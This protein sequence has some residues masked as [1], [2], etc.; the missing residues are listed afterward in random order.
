[1]GMSDK[2][3]CESQKRPELKGKMYCQRGLF[4]QWDLNHE[5]VCQGCEAVMQYIE[6]QNPLQETIEDK[7]RYDIQMGS[8]S[9]PEYDE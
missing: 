4:E 6:E 1:M 5:N 9:D 3:E 8:D 2:V 7:V